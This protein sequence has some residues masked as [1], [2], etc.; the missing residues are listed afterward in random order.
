[1]S[2]AL[3]NLKAPEINVFERQ[4]FESN[5]ESQRGSNSSNDGLKVKFN[6]NMS[7]FSVL[8]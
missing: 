4:T 2:S 1:L 6:V 7:Q 3:D 8:D 5:V